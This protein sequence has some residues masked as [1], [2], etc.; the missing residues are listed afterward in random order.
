M[1]ATD[2]T[3]SHSD[4]TDPVNRLADEFMKAN[5]I[6]TR[7]TNAGIMF[8]TVTVAGIAAGVATHYIT[9]PKSV[10]LAAKK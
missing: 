5:T 10:E 7:A 1:P 6:Q 8:V 4:K 9:R 2:T 3:H